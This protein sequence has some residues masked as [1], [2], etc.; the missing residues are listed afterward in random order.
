MFDLSDNFERP[1]TTHM[2]IASIV[3]ET[4]GVIVFGVL[5]GNM[6]DFIATGDDQTKPNPAR[7]APCP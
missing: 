7:P 2:L 6:S 5:V 4:S 1:F 3:L